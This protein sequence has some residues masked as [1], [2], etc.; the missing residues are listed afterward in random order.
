VFAVVLFLRL[1]LRPEVKKVSA[2][3]ARDVALVASKH[4]VCAYHL[5]M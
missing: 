4:Q 3:V 5:V 2:E 1:I